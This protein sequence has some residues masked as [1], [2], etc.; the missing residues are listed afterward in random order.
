MC[1]KCVCGVSLI[2]AQCSEDVLPSTPLTMPRLYHYQQLHS[3][4]SN[5][6]H[7]ITTLGIDRGVARRCMQILQIAADLTVP[8]D[9]AAAAAQR[10]SQVLLHI[11]HISQVSLLSTIAMLGVGS[12]NV[13]PSTA[14]NRAGKVTPSQWA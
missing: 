14:T 12:H 1:V 9:L 3:G 4:I 5:P 13:Q 11:L 7:F 6:S 10:C 2:L 8:A